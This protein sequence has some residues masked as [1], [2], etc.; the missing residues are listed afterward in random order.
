ML[1]VHTVASKIDFDMNG[2]AYMYQNFTGSCTVTA[3]PR[4]NVYMYMLPSMPD[5]TYQ[6]GETLQ[7][8]QYTTR[9]TTRVINMTANCRTIFC[10]T[11]V[12]QAHK[13]IGKNTIIKLLYH[14]LNLCKIAPT[15]RTH[16]AYNVGDT[17][18]TTIHNTVPYIH[19]TTA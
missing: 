13:V 3:N 9:A 2:T 16:T 6:L 10:S 1:C 7:T 19:N 4:M 14:P 18:I 17:D 5:C 8:D 15:T 12:F 11:N